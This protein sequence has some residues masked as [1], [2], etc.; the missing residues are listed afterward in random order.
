MVFIGKLLILAIDIYIFIIIA[1]VILQWLI[2]F[3][4]ISTQN[5]QAANLI[6]QINRVVDPVYQAMRRYLPIPPIGGID[7]SPI[8]LV[9]VLHIVQSIIGAVFIY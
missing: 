3:D 8:I 6:M 1:Q 9:L 4:V 5:P 7:I 2:R